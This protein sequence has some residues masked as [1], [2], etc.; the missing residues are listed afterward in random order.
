MEQKTL[1]KIIVVA[2]AIFF[3]LE[4]VAM[5]VIGKA[6]ENK[7]IETY[8]A[9]GTVEVTIT[10]YYPYLISSD[11]INESVKSELLAMDGVERVEEEAEGSVIAVT[12][13]KYV[14]P[15]YQFLKEN[16][17]SAYT[18]AQVYFPGDITL[19]GKTAY[20]Q[21]GVTL[22]MEPFVDENQRA[23]MLIKAEV[24]NGKVTKIYE[25][26]P[27]SERKEVALSGTVE[28]EI[29][30]KYVILVPWENRTLT[31]SDL[32]IEAESV[33]Y[34]TNNYV[35]INPQTPVSEKK[36][37]VTAI[38][39]GV[40]I[41]KQNFTNKSAVLQ[42]YSSYGNLTFPDSQIILVTNETLE[43]ISF[44][45]Q[46]Y[47]L[48]SARVFPENYTYHEIVVGY[49]SAAPLEIGGKVSVLMNATVSGSA[50]ISLEE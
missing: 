14:F 11:Y 48:Y 19:G 30:K 22:A 16:G 50:I 13:S 32:G 43:N 10:K 5:V 17:I 15:V 39:E 1:L 49:E 18:K 12:E 33:E 7:T 34:K 46:E 8:E 35:V 6:T 25:L 28:E 29:G 24:E 47:W 21:G 27:I 36:E 2:V 44:A 23:T 42:D 37:Y 3:M 26:K 4:S 41:V 40:I 9:S 20:L 38:G 45:M 31:A